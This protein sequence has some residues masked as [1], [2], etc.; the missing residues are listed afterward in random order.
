[1]QVRREWEQAT[2]QTR[3]LALAADSELRRRHPDRRYEPLRS[4]EPLVSEDERARLLADPEDLDYEQPGWIA[5]LADERRAVREEL[6]DRQSVRIPA[7]EADCGYEGQ[8]W[9]AWAAAHRDAIL[10]PPKP[11]IRPAHA[12]LDRAA[13]V[14]VEAER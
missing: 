13:E 5:G 4:V 1:M 8:A 11:D 9:P 3:R 6:A 12:V 14:Q 7:A 10:Q 2:A